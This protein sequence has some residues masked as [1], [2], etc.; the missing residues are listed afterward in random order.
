[1]PWN[2]KEEIQA[3]PDEFDTPIEYNKLREGMK[4]FSVKKINGRTYGK[5]EQYMEEIGVLS[6]SDKGQV[7][8]IVPAL[9]TKYNR[10]N[11]KIEALDWADTERLFQIA[12]EE[13]E[14]Y[15]VKRDGWFKEMRQMLTKVAVQAKS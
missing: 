10:M 5:W 15:E 9:Y 14:A 4:K 8:V 7:Q 12:P 3:A 1:M 2:K 13:R 11:S 6:F